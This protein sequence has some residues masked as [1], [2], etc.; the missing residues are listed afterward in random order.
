MLL[1]QFRGKSNLSRKKAVEPDLGT[2]HFRRIQRFSGSGEREFGGRFFGHGMAVR[3][4]RATGLRAGAQ[5][6][7]DDGL[8]GT[9]TTPTLGIAAEA[10]INLLCIA[11]QIRS[12]MYGTA[13][14]MVAEDV[15]GTDNHEV[16][17]PIGD[18]WHHR[19]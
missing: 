5:R 7:V 6:F 16:G 14:I 11:R 18:A 8:D 4:A 15:A 2:R 1:N 10:S 13:D 19:Y 9:R 3:A 12:G 17:E